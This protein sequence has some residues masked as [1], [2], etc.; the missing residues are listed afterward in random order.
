MF[1]PLSALLLLQFASLLAPAQQTKPNPATP[2]P[3]APLTPEQCIAQKI[4]RPQ[5]ID[6]LQVQ[7]PNVTRGSAITDGL[8]LLVTTID[9]TG[10]TSNTHVVH[11]T[12]SIFLISSLDAA[13]HLRFNPATT[14]DGKPVVIIY[15][16]LLRYHSIKFYFD[17]DLTQADS[18][19]E[20]LRPVHSGFTPVIGAATT[21][22]ADGIYAFT[23]SVAP[24][25]LIKFKDK[26]YAHEAFTH[27]GNSLCDILLTID[28]KG[29]PSDP[30]VTHCERPGLEQPAINSLLKSKFTPA[31]LHNKR[32][33]IRATLHLSYD[34]PIP[35]NR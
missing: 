28:E 10:L 11:C 7:Y 5:P 21:P 1:R 26:G 30:R 16:L 29:R 23:L 14:P 2:A 32:I 13:R 17:R 3:A 27:Q 9:T 35:Y 8:C 18:N 6:Q 34:D 20:I 31:K 12:D 22:D 4:I 15:N 25:H 24:P 33:A 19:R